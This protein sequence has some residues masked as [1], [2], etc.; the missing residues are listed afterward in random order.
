VNLL[1]PNERRSPE[2]GDTRNAVIARRRMFERGI[3]SAL[4]APL[5]A[6]LREN[7]IATGA[8]LLDAGCG[9]GFYLAHLCAAL[10]ADG[11]GIDISTPAIELAAKSYPSLT[12]AVANADRS[13]PVAS[14]SIDAVLSITARVNAAEFSRVLHS[15]GVAAIVVAGADDLAELREAVMGRA[16]E[17]DRA[18]VVIDA[19]SGSFELAHRL[20]VHETARL[21]RAAIDDLLAST[22]RGQRRSQK[23]ALGKVSPMEITMT[24]EVLVFVRMENGAC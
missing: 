16:D 13:L 22:Y 5:A 24:R 7:G 12:W 20:T 21:D 3:G 1:Q 15:R 2:P 23:G 6:I 18:A 4:V 8:T 9:E 14:D 19:L 11:C 10:G 17:K